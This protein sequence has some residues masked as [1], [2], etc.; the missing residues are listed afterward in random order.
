MGDR[1]KRFCAPESSL[2]VRL[3]SQNLAG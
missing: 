3:P 1:I 2:V